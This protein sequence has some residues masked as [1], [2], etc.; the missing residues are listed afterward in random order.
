MSRSPGERKRLP[1]RANRTGRREST[2]CGRNA[3]RRV[4]SS[5]AA[6]APGHGRLSGR[7]PDR[8]PRTRCLCRAASPETARAREAP[9]ERARPECLESLPMDHSIAIGLMQANAPRTTQIASASRA[10]RY[11]AGFACKAGSRGRWLGRVAGRFG[12]MLRVSG[13]AGGSLRRLLSVKL[14]RLAHTAPWHP[15]AVPDGAFGPLRLLTRVWRGVKIAPL[16]CSHPKRCPA[17]GADQ[18]AL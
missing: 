11:V 7:R 16:C 10:S 3:K 6:D 2:P 15:G 18:P 4:R 17:R 5:R 9:F 13:I 1:S 14:R 12:E 8:L